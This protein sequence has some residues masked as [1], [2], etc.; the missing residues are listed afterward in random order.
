MNQNRTRLY[1]RACKM[2][3][4]TNVYDKPVCD[5]GFGKDES[6]VTL[7]GILEHNIINSVFTPAL[8]DSIAYKYIEEAMEDYLTRYPASHSFKQ[9]V[10]I[11]FC[12][13]LKN[14]RDKYCLS[15]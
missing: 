13:W 4:E 9:R 10:K 12:A 5:I 14:V 11:K 6:K 3:S 1:K 8:N 7:V 2:L 15:S